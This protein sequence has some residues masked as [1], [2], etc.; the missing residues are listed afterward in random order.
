MYYNKLK[1]M[2]T[3][4]KTFKSIFSA[5]GISPSYTRIRIYSY[6]EQS[7][8]HPTV[9]EIYKALTDEL[10]TLSKT[11]VY[12]NLKLFTDKE[13][14]KAVNMSSSEMRYELY[15]I[16]HSHFKCDLCGTIYDIPHIEPGYNKDIIPGFIIKEEE[17]NLTGICPAC[18]KK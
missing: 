18:N 7:K 5:K 16:P 12:N 11:T 9:D 6:L 3:M 13:L 8:T 17:V 10:P 15:D 4:E 14:V 2:M 1:G